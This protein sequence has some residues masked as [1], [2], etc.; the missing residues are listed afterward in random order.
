MA[1]I[2]IQ[3]AR[4]KGSTRHLWIKYHNDPKFSDRQVCANTVDPD[5]KNWSDKGLHCLLFHLYRLKALLCA[6]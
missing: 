2:D 3:Y 4:I 6:L 1:Q 5:Q